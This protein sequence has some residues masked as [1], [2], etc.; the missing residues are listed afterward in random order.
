M[1]EKITS[2]APADNWYARMKGS[3]D[4]NLK[5]CVWALTESGDIRGV[6]A[7]AKG[8]SFADAG[9]DFRDYVFLPMG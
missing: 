8:C 4:F 5:L 1:K 9:G 2:I 3:P 7:D 6:V